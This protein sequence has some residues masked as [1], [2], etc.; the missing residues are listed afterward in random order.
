M[1]KK[2]LTPAPTSDVP[3]TVGLELGVGRDLGSAARSTNVLRFGS[4]SAT[5]SAQY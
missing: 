1:P 3:F 4:G 2:P 5:T